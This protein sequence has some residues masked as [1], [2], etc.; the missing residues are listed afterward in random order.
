MKAGAIQV[1]IQIK[2][3]EAS[4]ADFK[5]DEWLA[6]CFAIEISPRY[7]SSFYPSDHLKA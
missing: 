4:S 1:A 6:F 7:I 5:S 2:S 3:E